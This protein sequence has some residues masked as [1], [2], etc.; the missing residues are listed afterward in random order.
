MMMMI[1]DDIWI[2]VCLF[3]DVTAI[4][5][6]RSVNQ[7]L[8]LL[9][10]EET[11]WRLLLQRDFTQWE[12]ESISCDSMDELYYRL[13]D[14]YNLPFV[15]PEERVHQWKQMLKMSQVI[16]HSSTNEYM[17]Q[18][19]SILEQGVWE[20]P[21][22]IYPLHKLNYGNVSL[23]PNGMN[24]DRNPHQIQFCVTSCSEMKRHRNREWYYRNARAILCIFELDA[25]DNS[26]AAPGTLPM[27]SY[28]NSLQSAQAWIHQ[29]RSQSTTP[30]LLVGIHSNPSSTFLMETKRHKIQQYC[31]EHKIPYFEIHNDITC[32]HSQLKSLLKCIIELPEPAMDTSLRGK[33]F[34]PCDIQ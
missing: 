12:I 31:K 19:I 11:I 24:K 14:K 33:R 7:Q 22:E 27:F 3:V 18:M 32:L 10:K 29:I 20:H 16:L 17:Y 5:T 28:N 34:R 4:R 30:V 8:S 6:L 26:L 2:N 21:S 9:L 25:V 1:N 15:Y 23:V 13:N